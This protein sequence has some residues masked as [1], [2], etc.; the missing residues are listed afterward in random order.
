MKI[1]VRDVQ[2]L[3]LLRVAG[4]VNGSSVIHGGINRLQ[5]GH[6]E[7]HIDTE[8]LPDRSDHQND[9]GRGAAGEPLDAGAAQAL[10]DTVD[11]TGLMREQVAEHDAHDSN[12]D[13][14]RHEEHGTEE[15]CTLQFSGQQEGQDQSQRDF[16]C[17]FK[18]CEYEGVLD[19]EPEFGRTF[20]NTDEVLQTDEPH[21]A[22]ALV[23]HGA[24]THDPQQ[25]GEPSN[26]SPHI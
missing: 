24:E 19:R 22:V 11:D 20:K 16:H 14:G 12:G 23:V 18:G 13:H 10:E 3:E 8:V 9:H 7:Q 17:K 5:A 15:V 1:L 25:S 26:D 21:G 4:T 2:R 6:K